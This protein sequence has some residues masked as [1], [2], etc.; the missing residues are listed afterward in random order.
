MT[1][2]EYVF[3][4]KKFAFD[5]REWYELPDGPW[6]TTAGIEEWEES[7]DNAHGGIDVSWAFHKTDE[8]IEAAAVC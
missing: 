2:K 1:I 7:C 5:S 3:I 8:T 4:C 6:F